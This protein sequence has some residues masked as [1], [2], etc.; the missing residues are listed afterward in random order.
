[1]IPTRGRTMCAASQH[2]CIFAG[3]VIIGL[4]R[5]RRSN[6]PQP[7]LEAARLHLITVERRSSK[8]WQGGSV[9]AW[10]QSPATAQLNLPLRKS[11]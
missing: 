10:A 1:M 5:S 4:S 11:A 9:A 2:S 3:V 6:Q 7:N 8:I